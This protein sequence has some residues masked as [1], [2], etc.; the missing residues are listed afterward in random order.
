MSFWPM[1]GQGPLMNRLEMSSQLTLHTLQVT[2]K[3]NL[4]LD[5]FVGTNNHRQ[6]LLFGCGVLSSED[7]ESYVKWSSKRK[8]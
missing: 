1:K 3:Y 4:A 7:T 6:L 5:V 8:K 2:N